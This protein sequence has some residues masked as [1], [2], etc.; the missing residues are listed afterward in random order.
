MLRKSKTKDLKI[1]NWW[2]QCFTTCAKSIG[3]GWDLRKNPCSRFWNWG[4]AMGLER[5]PRGKWMIWQLAGPE[6][7]LV[8]KQAH[9]LG[10]RQSGRPF[11]C[12]WRPDLG[13]KRVAPW[14]SELRQVAGSPWLVSVL[15][16]RLPRRVLGVGPAQPLCKWNAADFWPQVPETLLRPS[17]R[18]TLLGSP[19]VSVVKSLPANAGDAGS[20][21]G[22]GRSHMPWSCEAHAPHLLHLR[23]RAWQVQQEKPPQWAAGSWRVT[24]ARCN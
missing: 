1:V 15:W 16:H 21:P 8:V 19:G 12:A 2:K 13:A 22:P 4:R 3:A 10:Q 11:W 24:P 23:N 9:F 7:G 18:R 5:N 17:S 20:I 6:I 14:G